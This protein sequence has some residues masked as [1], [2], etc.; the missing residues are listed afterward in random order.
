MGDEESRREDAKRE[1]WEDK[2]TIGFCSNV[3]DGGRECGAPIF[4]QIMRA[5]RVDPECG[6]GTCSKC[7]K[8][9]SW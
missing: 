4:G 3:T 2:N 9:Y 8:E 7:G 1:E 5:T 6:E